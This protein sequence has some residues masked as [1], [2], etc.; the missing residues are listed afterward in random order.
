[1]YFTRLSNG[2]HDAAAGWTGFEP[3][4]N[5][6][7]LKIEYLRKFF[8]GIEHKYF[9]T[10]K[11]ESAIDVLVGFRVVSRPGVLLVVYGPE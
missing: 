6:V 5:T 1:M 10:V 2:L 11:E 9:E 3:N 4:L 7:E 8:L